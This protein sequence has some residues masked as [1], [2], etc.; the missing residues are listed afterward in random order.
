MLMQVTTPT[1][2][3]DKG[4]PQPIPAVVE[5]TSTWKSWIHGPKRPRTKVE[6][7]NDMNAELEAKIPAVMWNFSQN[8]LDNVMESL[9][10]IKGDNSVKIVGP[11]LDQ[12][13]LLAT[14]FKNEMDKIPGMA[15]VG[16]FHIRGQSHLE[17]RADPDKC[18]QWGVMPA[19]VNNVI[20]SALRQPPE[21]HG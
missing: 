11:D 5:E 2:P 19:D 8:I 14:K 20:D 7:I 4:L 21:Q 12:L 17:L 3:A 10:G 9:S 15:N 13:E 1:M 6:L 18:R 16:I